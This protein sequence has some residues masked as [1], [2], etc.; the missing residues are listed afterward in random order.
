M[1]WLGSMEVRVRVDLSFPVEDKHLKVMRSAATCLTNDRQSVRVHGDADTAQSSIAE[2]TM[3]GIRKDDAAGVVMRFA[4]FM[5]D[6]SDQTVWF[7][8]RE[9]KRRRKR[10]RSKT[11]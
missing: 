5:P 3:V 9:R 4:A 10:Q 2:F 8:T 11:S 1:D 6:Y 7:P